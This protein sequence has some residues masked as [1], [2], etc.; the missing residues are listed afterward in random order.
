MF[1]KCAT[2]A[3]RADQ[4][5]QFAEGDKVEVQWDKDHEWYPATVD[6]AWYGLHRIHYDEDDASDDEWVGP[7]AIRL[8]SE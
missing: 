7:Q 4:P 3:G 5:A 2:S 8:R 6:A 1:S